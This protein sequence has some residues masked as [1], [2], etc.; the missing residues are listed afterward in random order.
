[1][2]GVKE[3]TCADCILLKVVKVDLICCRFDWG[4]S[5]A[6]PLSLLQIVVVVFVAKRLGVELAKVLIQL[7]IL[8][9]DLVTNR[10]DVLELSR[11]L[12]QTVKE[13]LDDNDAKA[14]SFAI[15]PKGFDDKLESDVLD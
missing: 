9:L 4:S 1:M 11:E 14:S 15:S 2:R 7:G 10:V 3:R 8:L 12:R 5:S 6:F 13:L